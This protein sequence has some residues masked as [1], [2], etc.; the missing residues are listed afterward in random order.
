[1]DRVLAGLICPSRTAALKID[2][3]PEQTMALT[4]I[5]YNSTVFLVLDSGYFGGN[6]EDAAES[7]IVITIR[8]QINGWTTGMPISS[9]ALLYFRPAGGN[10][11]TDPDAVAI[12]V[13]SPRLWN[14]G[15]VHVSYVANGAAGLPPIDPGSPYEVGTVITVLGNVGSPQL[16]RPGFT[17]IGWERDIVPVVLVS[18][19]ERFTIGIGYSLTGTG[20][21]GYVIKIDYLDNGTVLTQSTTGFDLT[22]ELTTVDAEGRWVY[23]IPSKFGNEFAN[24]EIR[25]E[26]LN[27]DTTPIFYE[28]GKPLEIPQSK[29]NDSI[30]R[31]E[32]V[33]RPVWAPSDPEGPPSDVWTSGANRR[34]G[35][36]WNDAGEGGAVRYE[37]KRYEVGASQSDIDNAEWLNIPLGG[38]TYLPNIDKYCY[39][40]TNLT[41]GVEYMFEVRA[42]DSAGL[43]GKT[44]KVTGT[45]NPFGNIGGVEADLI[46]IHGVTVMPTGGWPDTGGNFWYVPHRATVSMPASI[47]VIFGTTS[48]IGISTDAEFIMYT[49]AGFVSP[50]T[51]INRYGL[52]GLETV[53]V[54]FRVTSGNTENWK[55]YAITIVP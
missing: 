4:V 19:Y 47:P 52:S 36:I 43:V 14:A 39:L 41:N 26:Y 8:F 42:Y 35:L 28:I 38:M 16:S 1:M 30:N 46:S 17:L 45:P 27:P 23:T 12:K 34:I 44:E 20:E 31:R 11:P 51:M 50:T 2:G 9:E 32:L 29:I 15:P 5:P 6:F 48:T 40:Y 53:T 54:Y 49:D 21:P 10:Y 24:L 22:Q 37:V 13:I 3:G 18:E 7:E 33:L 25:G 55:Y